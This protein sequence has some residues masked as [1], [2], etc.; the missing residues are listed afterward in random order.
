MEGKE[1]DGLQ[2]EA[3]LDTVE[4]QQTCSVEQWAAAMSKLLAEALPCSALRTQHLPVPSPSHRLSFIFLPCLSA[5]R[6][7]YCCTLS[8]PRH[9]RHTFAY[10]QVA[11]RE[12]C[13]AYP[14]VARIPEPGLTVAAQ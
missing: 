4:E 11:G 7:T 3:C 5:G 12:T 6:P 8:H 2:V 13:A 14:E 9:H 10:V 1:V